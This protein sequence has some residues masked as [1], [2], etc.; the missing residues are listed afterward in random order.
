MFYKKCKKKTQTHAHIHSF[1][2]NFFKRIVKY[3]KKRIK[4]WN[5]NRKI[6]KATGRKRNVEKK[7]Y[8]ICG[9]LKFSR[10]KQ[11]IKERNLKNTYFKYYQQ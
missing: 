4:Y 10:R 7:Q 3:E 8:F 1:I 9:V 11:E 2:D 5:N 6:I